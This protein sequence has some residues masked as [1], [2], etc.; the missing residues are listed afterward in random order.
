MY[1]RLKDSAPLICCRVATKKMPTVVI[2]LGVVIILVI[3]DIL[4]FRVPDSN[5][6][7]ISFGYRFHDYSFM[8]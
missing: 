5:N 7:T 8:R 2:I 1:L 4:W 6:V 3:I